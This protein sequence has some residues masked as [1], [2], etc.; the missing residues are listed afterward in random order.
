MQYSVGIW[1]NKKNERKLLNKTK[2]RLLKN[3]K[4]E[5]WS[6]NENEI[7]TRTASEKKKKKNGEG[8]K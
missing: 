3:W 4:I 5:R 8:E 1:K 6:H 7:K 2:K